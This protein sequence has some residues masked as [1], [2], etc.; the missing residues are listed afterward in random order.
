MEMNDSSN[1]SAAGGDLSRYSRFDILMTYY[2][3][4]YAIPI[5]YSLIIVLGTVGNSMV[6]FVILYRKK[7]RTTVNMMLLNLAF[8]DIAFLVT[9]VPFQAHK[10]AASTWDFPDA[11]CKLAQYSLFVTAY[12]TVYTLMSIALLRYFTVVWSGETAHLRTKRN[13]VIVCVG[14]WVVMLLVNIPTLLRH[15]VH[16]S[17]GGYEFCG[18]DTE[19]M[20]TIITTFFVFAYLLPLAAILLIYVLLIRY[21]RNKQR[22]SSVRSQSQSKT[23]R[24]SRTVII[25]IAAFAILWLPS[26]AQSLF[27]TYGFIPQ[28]TVYEI[29]RSFFHSMSY[30]NSVVNPIIYNFSSDDFRSAFKQLLSCSCQ[31]APATTSSSAGCDLRLRTN[32]YSLRVTDVGDCTPLREEATVEREER[33]GA[34][35][36]RL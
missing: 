5:Y 21:L 12:V 26:H 10:Y 33:N 35:D 25:V 29:F 9:C 32:S 24:A 23:T 30:A 20:A 6:I 4:T 1:S 13:V 18:M 17:T 31:Q 8:A 22:S 2:L 19:A 34:S 36:S 15:R 27:F 28:A 11:V 14:I 7:M 3:W 16:L